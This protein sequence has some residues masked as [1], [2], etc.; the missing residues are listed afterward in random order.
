MKPVS[1]LIVIL[2]QIN[3]LGFSI[4][5]YLTSWENMNLAYLM[6]QAL[7]AL[8]LFF[9]QTKNKP[10]QFIGSIILIQLSLCL[11]VIQNERNSQNE[12]TA[13]VIIVHFITTQLFE[14]FKRFQ[15][16]Y[17]FV[18]CR[19][20]WL[21]LLLQSSFLQIVYISQTSQID[22]SFYQ[23]AIY[24]FF[25]LVIN[26]TNGMQKVII[27][28]NKLS[29]SQRNQ[30]TDQ[31]INRKERASSQ[32]DSDKL[33]PKSKEYPFSHFLM[34]DYSFPN[35]ILNQNILDVM[36]Q[37]THEGLMVLRLNQLNQ[38]MEIVFSNIA[39]KTLFSVNSAKEII[40]ILNSLNSLKYQQHD[41]QDENLLMMNQQK[42]LC[43]SMAFL[44]SDQINQ[45]INPHYQ[46]LLE[47]NQEKNIVNQ[48]KE[49]FSK[50]KQNSFQNEFFTL[51]TIYPNNGVT[52]S[53]S[54]RKT[55]KMLELT[56]TKK[57][58][59]L[60][61]ILI[62]DITHKQKI[63][64]LREYDLQKSKMLSYV[65]HEYRSPLNCIIQMIENVLHT[66]QLTMDNS[67]MLQ[68]A[69]DN[70]YYILNLS[71]DLLDLAQIKNGKFALQQTRFNLEQLIKECLK[72]FALKAKILKLNLSY[73][74]DNKAPFIVVSDRNR[75]KQILVNLLSNSFKFASNQITIIVS[76]IDNTTIRIGVQD[77]GIGISDEDQKKL[78]KQF[79]KVN[80]EESRK[81]NENGVGLGLVISNQI[82][83][84][85]GCGGLQ[86]D[87]KLNQGTYFFF[88][89]QI[90]QTRLK[91]VSSYRIKEN[92]GQSQDVDEG[93]AFLL[94]PKKSIDLEPPPIRCSHI[95]I[96][97]DEIFNVF[98]F[99]KLLNK[100]NIVDID[101]ASNGSEC[102]EKLRNKKCCQTCSGYR[103]IFMDLEMPIL[104]GFNAAKE[105]LKINPNQIIIACSGYTDH[106]EKEQCQ[107]IG[108]LNYLVKPIRDQELTDIL[109][110]YYF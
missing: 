57:E 31:L 73:I 30:N 60:F 81:R 79:S 61:F 110:T 14:D 108:I 70:S 4:Y 42:Q 19:L 28:R 107:K 27:P 12:S 52:M 9:F 44:K 6:I 87:S 71:N 49:I 96:V 84:S 100:K 35:Q 51:H 76:Y 86:I 41:Q 11:F 46:I 105:V 34:P 97:D 63:K 94:E 62:R 15:T 83:S 47:M 64:Y 21:V 13:Y 5:Y 36:M 45:S 22:I 33:S 109:T 66:N 37:F 16:Q 17:F 23:C 75:I 25:S 85:I 99:I 98:T 38:D 56:I 8:L 77:D 69:L 104:N 82:A 91:K 39:S 3:G 18:R 24:L 103:M 68:A 72:L 20:F 55:E 78:F 106:K 93:Q 74:Y 102:I 1:R 58:N 67:E 92:P 40:D 10:T 65:S 7:L 95:L 59:N 32:S 26:F 48:F 89:L 29:D 101:S 2:F 80:S 53:Q 54:E 88:N 90:Q 43:K 50:F